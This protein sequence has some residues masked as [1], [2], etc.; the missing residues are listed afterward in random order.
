MTPWVRVIPRCSHA[1]SCHPERANGA[2]RAGEVV[3][4]PHLKIESDSLN[5]AS[6]LL[7]IQDHVFVSLEGAKTPKDLP[8]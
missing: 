1:H 8:S 3:M 6:K 5:T 7:K 2:L 4:T